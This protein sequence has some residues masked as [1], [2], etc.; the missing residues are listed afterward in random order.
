MQT[1]VGSD[2]LTLALPCFF[3]HNAEMVRHDALKMAGRLQMPAAVVLATVACHIALADEDLLPR[4]ACIVSPQVRC[5]A[6]ELSALDEIQEPIQG[7]R[8]AI[9]RQED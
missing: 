5:H 3:Q 7:R 1:A 9:T 8:R 6:T 4:A 2:G